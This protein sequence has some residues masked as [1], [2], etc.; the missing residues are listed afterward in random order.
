M[1]KEL[2]DDD[3]RR[4]AREFVLG[5]SPTLDLDANECAYLSLKVAALIRSLL[6]EKESTS[7]IE[8]KHDKPKH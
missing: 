4:K 8:R 6:V 3:A 1:A 2:F 5:V 7:F